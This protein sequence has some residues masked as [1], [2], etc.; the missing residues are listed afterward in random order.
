MSN[1]DRASERTAAAIAGGYT[2]RA[3]ERKIQI[4]RRITGMNETL[5]IG[6]DDPL[7]PGDTVYVEERFF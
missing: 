2:E 3:N 1:L 7:R 4:T 6:P 5:H